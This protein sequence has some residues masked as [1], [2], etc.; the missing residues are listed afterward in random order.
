ML[1]LHPDT[2]RSVGRRASSHFLKGNRTTLLPG[3]V[4]RWRN[5]HFD[6]DIQVLIANMVSSTASSIVFGDSSCKGT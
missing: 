6:H 2:D 4:K 3:R 1:H 5:C